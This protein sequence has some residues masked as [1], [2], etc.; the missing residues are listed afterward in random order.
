MIL[1][2]EITFKNYISKAFGGFPRPISLELDRNQVQ[3]CILI[4]ILMNS[5]DTN[6]KLVNT[7]LSHGMALTRYYG[8][9]DY[10]DL[11]CITM[12]PGTSVLR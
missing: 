10:R 12:S 2:A 7:D 5:Q 3:K 1:V 8:T 6:R 11:W 4:Q 9:S